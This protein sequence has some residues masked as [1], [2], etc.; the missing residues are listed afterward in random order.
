MQSLREDADL[1]CQ[2]ILIEPVQ[3]PRSELGIHLQ[4]A[5]PYNLP[6]GPA[7]VVLQPLVPAPNHQLLIRNQDT[8]RCERI[9]P[10]TGNFPRSFH[11]RPYSS[12]YAASHASI[13]AISRS[14]ELTPNAMTRNPPTALP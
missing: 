7:G 10:A 2:R 1:A 6:S 11:L 8:Q 14:S 4:E 3:P 9:Q 12:T 13:P 5:T